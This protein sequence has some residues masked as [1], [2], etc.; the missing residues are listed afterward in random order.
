[1]AKVGALLRSDYPYIAGSYG[2]GAGYPNTPGICSQA[3]R[4]MIG[5]GTTQLWGPLTQTQVKRLLY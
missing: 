2:S 3:D 1:M 4:I 5:P